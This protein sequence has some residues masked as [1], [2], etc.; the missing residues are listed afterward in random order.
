MHDQKQGLS[1]IVAELKAEVRV[2]RS[3]N[4][5][6]TQRN[7]VFFF[8]FCSCTFEYCVLVLEQIP[9]A[10]SEEEDAINSALEVS[11]CHTMLSAHEWQA[12]VLA[13]C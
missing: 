5:A 6:E 12:H 4:F 10:K 8:F 1:N 7:F 3:F 13:A 11:P 9:D 2:A